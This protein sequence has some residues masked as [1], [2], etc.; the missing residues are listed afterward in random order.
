MCFANVFLP[1]LLLLPV[2]ELN[3]QI[4]FLCEWGKLLLIFQDSD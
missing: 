4:H 2:P 1:L 3:F